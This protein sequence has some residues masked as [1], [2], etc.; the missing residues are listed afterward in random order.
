MP[1]SAVAFNGHARLA[2]FTRNS[3]S[4]RRVNTATDRALG[5]V[6]TFAFLALR[7]DQNPGRFAVVCRTVGFSLVSTS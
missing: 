3:F 5:G 4:R 1:L 7:S 6:L 2:L